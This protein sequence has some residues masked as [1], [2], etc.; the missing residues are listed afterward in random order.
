MPVIENENKYEIKPA[1]ILA[2]VVGWSCCQQNEI[3]EKVSWTKRAFEFYFS[4][5]CRQEI[6][7]GQLV[8]IAVA[9]LKLKNGLTEK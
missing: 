8:H 9:K 4:F 3:S 1:N 2:S 5:Y 6:Q 7:G